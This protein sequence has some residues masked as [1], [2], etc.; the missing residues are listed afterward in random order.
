MD[1]QQN[2]YMSNNFQ[3]IWLRIQKEC[4]IKSLTQLA[5]IIGISQP[6]VSK[7]K[8]EN[9]FPVEWAYAIAQKYNLSTEWI[10][11]GQGPKRLKQEIENNYFSELVTWAK[12][13]GQ[14]DNIN[15]VTNQID[16]MFPMFKEWRKR[17]DETE[18]GDSES[19][20]SKI[21]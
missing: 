14:S 13:T 2:N 9:L 19:P 4:S 11:T 12:E 8:K 3:T 7:R 21:A 15:W 5:E 1:C 18:G 16:G 20:A 10:M 17:K 6:N